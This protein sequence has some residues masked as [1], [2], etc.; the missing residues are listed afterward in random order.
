MGNRTINYYEFSDREPD[1]TKLK[2]TFKR[3]VS[4]Y[5]VP[6]FEADSEAEGQFARFCQASNLGP[7]KKTI[8][9]YDGKGT[10]P[11]KFLFLCLKD[12][13]GSC[14]SEGGQGFLDLSAACPGGGPFGSCGRGARQVD[15]VLVKPEGVQ[16]VTTLGLLTCRYPSVPRVFLISSMVGEALKRAGASGCEIVPT[17]N[18]NCCQLR[19]TSETA[20][21]A[22]IGQ[23]RMGKR[24]PICGTAKMF[25]GS[26]ER[27]F[28]NGDLK[29]TDFQICRLYAAGNVGKFEILNGFPIVSQRIFNVLLDLKIKGLARYS[30]DPPIQHAVVQFGEV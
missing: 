5:N 6:F 25:I 30:T 11:E 14:I 29:P 9:E 26:S 17:D 18:P 28:H 20:G 3:N 12:D 16:Q 23:A 8:I 22:R 13:D 4:K 19:I 27:H 24:C 15:K 2:Q 7:H 10:D 1:W 21:P